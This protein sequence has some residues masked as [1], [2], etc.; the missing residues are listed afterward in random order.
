MNQGLCNRDGAN[1]LEVRA[2]KA[3]TPRGRNSREVLAAPPDRNRV[4][5]TDH[6]RR[7]V[8]INP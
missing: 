5:T 8:L 7:G 4:T 3:K 2:A 6:A 1:A